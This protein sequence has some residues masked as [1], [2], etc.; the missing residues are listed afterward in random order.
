MHG[1]VHPEMGHVRLP[2]EPSDDFPGCCPF[3]GDCLEGL[4]SGPAIQQRWGAPAETLPE[5]HPAWELEASYLA[6]AL[7]NIVCT[8]SPQRIAVG[9]GVAEQPALVPM[10]RRRVRDL[11]GGYLRAPWLLEDVDAYIVRPEL[12]GRAGVLGAIALARQLT[13][14]G[15]QSRV[16]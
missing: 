11:L 7:A 13:P 12:G 10:V 6:T 2:R 3:H 5:D 1:L 4:A 16:P 9:G 15:T 8:L 14:E